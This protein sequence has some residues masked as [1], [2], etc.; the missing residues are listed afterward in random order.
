MFVSFI[1]HSHR[2]SRHFDITNWIASYYI[3]FGT[4][5]CGGNIDDDYETEDY[6]GPLSCFVGEVDSIPSGGI[7]TLPLE[8]TSL[9]EDNLLEE[10]D[11]EEE[12][13][14]DCAM[15]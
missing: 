10:D 15:L 6:V 8:A 12:A 13:C 14:W 9:I 2:R 11:E 7:L 4:N 5:S 3:I 1:Y